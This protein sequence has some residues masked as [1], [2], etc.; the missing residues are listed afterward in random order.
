MDITVKFNPK[1]PE[2]INKT[3]NLS[4]LFKKFIDL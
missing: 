4:I 3:V 1:T 2:S